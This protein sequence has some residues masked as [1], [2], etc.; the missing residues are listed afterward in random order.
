MLYLLKLLQLLIV[1]Q[2]RVAC[3]RHQRCAF[4]P[5]QLQRGLCFLCA[6]EHCVNVITSRRGFQ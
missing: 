4:L 3:Q 5:R 6:E 1:L 2:G